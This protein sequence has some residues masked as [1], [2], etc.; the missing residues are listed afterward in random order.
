[1]CAFAAS[2]YYLVTVSHSAGRIVGNRARLIVTRYAGTENESRQF[3]NVV[4]D[5]AEK[6]YR[7]SLHDGRRE[8]KNPIYIPVQETTRVKQRRTHSQLL[9]LRQQMFNEQPWLNQ[10][11]SNP[12]Q[13]V[14]FAPVV[15]PVTSG[16]SLTASAVVSADRR[17]VRIAIAPRFTNVTDVFT[18][19]FVNGGQ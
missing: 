10:I 7:I 3:V 8:K 14:G 4:F 6:K 2:G 11:R 15:V 16:S 19:S 9:T 17:Y 5:K 12:S 18:F 13:A 1:M